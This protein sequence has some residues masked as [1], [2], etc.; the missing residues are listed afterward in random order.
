MEP[1]VFWVEVGCDPAMLLPFSPYSSKKPSYVTVVW[2]SEWI[3]TWWRL[4]LWRGRYIWCSTW[5]LPGG[6]GVF[7]YLL[8]PLPSLKSLSWSSNWVDQISSVVFLALETKKNINSQIA[9]CKTKVGFSVIEAKQIL[10]LS[11]ICHFK[12][13]FEV[14]SWESWGLF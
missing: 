13:I 7:P 9:E 6:G 12:Q 1:N 5:R 8:P 2:N 4:S 3:R 14:E 10:H 11:R